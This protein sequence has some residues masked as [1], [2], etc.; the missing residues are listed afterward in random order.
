M[1]DGH[2]GGM[3]EGIVVDPTARRSP[4]PSRGLDINLKLWFRHTEVSLE[5]L[6]RSFISRNK[7]ESEKT[8][9]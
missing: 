5:R 7:W 6:L 8:N 9:D 4:I 2:N 3:V 1:L